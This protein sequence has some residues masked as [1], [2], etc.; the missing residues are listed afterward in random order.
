M[1]PEQSEILAKLKEIEAQ[2]DHLVRELA[3]I[4]SL[5]RTRINHIVGLSGYLRTLIGSQLTLVKLEAKSP[6]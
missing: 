5:Q 6:E 4:P 2:A 1:S 3:D